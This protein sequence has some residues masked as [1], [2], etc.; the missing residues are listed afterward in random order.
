M[1][2][3]DHRRPS[4]AQRLHLAVAAGWTPEDI[5]GRAEQ[6]GSY[7][8]AYSDTRVLAFRLDRLLEQAA[9]QANPDDLPP[10][11]PTWLAA[12]PPADLYAP[13]DEYLP[14]RYAEM[15][16]RVTGLCQEAEDRVP[17]WMACIGDGPGR[18]EASRQV[19]AYRAV[20]A[21]DSAD[22]LGPEPDLPGRQRQAW[23]AAS[24]AIAASQSFDRP[25]AT[26]AAQLATVL[27]HEQPAAYEAGPEI[28][29][30]SPGRHL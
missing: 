8:D 21:V 28:N 20:Y 26:G 11:V 27:G 23:H 9:S 12:R 14:A 18:P 10:E 4:V 22:P 3:R 2:S 16:D 17:T 6:M 24:L 5:L 1:P 29:R 25:T 13:W 30:T 19:V 7:A 15:A